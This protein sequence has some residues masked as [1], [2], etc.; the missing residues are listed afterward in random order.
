V[1]REEIHTSRRKP[2]IVFDDSDRPR[3][4][5]SDSGRPPPTARQPNFA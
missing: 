1:L 4:T 3:A 2:R 5:R